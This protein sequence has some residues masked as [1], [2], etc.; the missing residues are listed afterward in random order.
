LDVTVPA[1]TLAIGKLDKNSKPPQ[2]A[3]SDENVIE[4]CIFGGS[5]MAF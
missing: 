3:V 5:N 4:N 2:S 1:D